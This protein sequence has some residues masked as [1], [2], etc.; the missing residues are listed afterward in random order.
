VNELVKHANQLC[1]VLVP[2]LHDEKHDISED[3]NIKSKYGTH[4]SC[5][6]GFFV[7]VVQHEAV[8]KCQELEAAMEQMI[9]IN[10][11]IDVR[12]TV[13]RALHVR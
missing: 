8:R 11:L 1:S 12:T 5:P 7:F 10:N 2:L 13:P 6:V 4:L 9:N 3:G